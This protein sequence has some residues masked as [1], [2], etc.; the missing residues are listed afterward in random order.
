MK[1][2][3]ALT[4]IFLSLN[5]FAASDDSI[6][7]LQWSSS[8]REMYQRNKKFIARLA[9][10]AERGEIIGLEL[11][12][13]AKSDI[14]IESKF[15][16]ALIHFVDNDQDPGNDI[17]VSFVADVDAPE[18]SNVAGL[19]GRYS[20]YPLVKTMRL[21]IRQYIKQDERPLERHIIP[22]SEKMREDLI[23]TL[24][25]WWD[26]IL[27]GEEVVYNKS[28]VKATK[29][30]KKKGIE[31][32]GKDNF[33]TFDI[34]FYDDIQKKEFT[35]SIGIVEKE[36][37][38]FTTDKQRNEALYKQAYKRSFKK[39]EALKKENSFKINF[40]QQLWLLEKSKKTLYISENDEESAKALALKYFKEVPFK[41][42]V[43]FGQ[44]MEK[45]GFNAVAFEDE[46]KP[47]EYLNVFEKEKITLTLKNLKV[48]GVISEHM[49]R[50][51]FFSNNCAGAAINFFK[52]ANFPHKRG[53]GMQG[54]I[55]SKLNKWMSRSFLVPYPPIKIDRAEILKIE[56]SR[57][58]GMTRKDFETYKFPL[59]QWK[60]MSPL[61]TLEEKFLFFDIFIDVITD[62]YAALVRLEIEGQEAPNY[63][64]MHGLKNLNRELY[65]LCSNRTCGKKR[66]ELVKSIWTKKSIKAVKK[67][68]NRSG[69]NRI[70]YSGLKKRPEVIEHLKSIKYLKKSF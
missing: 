8:H 21:F 64:S 44:D 33:E 67:L 48:K 5:L 29:K 54:R 15:G 66:L 36:V 26:E 58:L 55:P 65:T 51:T 40:G 27:E 35:Y 42:F 32:F 41:L 52:E 12:I 34:T 11:I 31:L 14:R 45:L 7:F 50:Y 22:S 63:N 25:T 3:L 56:L 20:I 61:L 4:L 59:K 49:G 39:L 68:V 69:N 43:N 30:A 28:L 24:M 18:T 6:E 16:H 13:A 10:R 9:K 37:T 46:I 62:E 38:P 17:A 70:I 23:N 1:I 2:T 53:M 60:I 57:I 19:V 47:L